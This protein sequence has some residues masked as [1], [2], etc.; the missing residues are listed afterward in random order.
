MA[1]RRSIP[2]TA[3]SGHAERLERGRLEMRER[4]CAAAMRLFLEE[5]FEQTSMRRI[6]DAIGYSP[7][8]IY[9]YFEDKDEILFALHMEGFAKLRAALQAVDPTL[10]AHERLR[11]GGEA[12]LRFAFENPE[13]YDLMFITSRTVPRIRELDHWE[14][15]ADTY[16]FLRDI[17]RDAMG[18]GAIPP[19]EVDAAA[20]AVWAAVHGMAA[21]VIRSRCPMLPEAQ[22]A[23][24][25]SAAY[26]WTHAALLAPAAPTVPQRAVRSTAKRT[27]R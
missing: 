6:A 9:S 5:G 23:D 11:H 13:Y 2:A 27:K 18:E 24:I 1:E 17:V 7:G 14:V 4:I 21:L 12:Y 10:P 25:V 16:E 22:I 8:A 19:G 20:F 26:A 3:R 15:G